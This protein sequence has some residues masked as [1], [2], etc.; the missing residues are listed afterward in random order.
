M[1]KYL[2]ARGASAVEDEA[3]HPPVVSVLFRRPADSETLEKDL[4][5]LFAQVEEGPEVEPLRAPWPISRECYG[6]AAF[7]RDA[8]TV[9]LHFPTAPEDLPQIKDWLAK[10]EVES[11]SIRLC[12]YSDA[13]KFTAIASAK[14]AACSGS[15][16]YLDPRVHGIE[17]EHLSCAACGGMFEVK[18]FLDALPAD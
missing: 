7:F 15:L 5:L 12:E 10:H 11:A 6:T 1:P 2:R 13:K 18:T 4:D 17:Q 8:K 3:R 14:C 9:G 16:E